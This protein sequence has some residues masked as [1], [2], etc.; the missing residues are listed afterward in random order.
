MATKKKSR[1]ASSAGKVASA[2]SP[3]QPAKAPTNGDRVTLAE[4]MATLEQ[5]GNEQT[6]NT[7]ARHGAQGPM[8]GVKLGD[9]AKLVTR[10]GV[11]HELAMELWNTGNADARTLAVK[12]ADPARM[13]EAD[14]DRWSRE[15]N[16]RL[17]VDYV[18]QLAS[19]G[20]HAAKKA[21]QWLPKKDEQQGL[22]GWTLVGQL[23]M[24][25]AA[26][27]DRWFRDRLAEIEKRIGA[28][29]NLQRAAMNQALIA[30]GGRSAALRD[31]AFAA[32]K[33]IGKVVV[34]HGD[35]SC[36]TPDAVPCLEKMWAHAQAK[37]FE[38]PAAQERTREA[39]RCRC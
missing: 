30:I 37:G 32:S 8:F 4:A 33:R 19:E 22:A 20:P 7:W 36:K 24:R 11:D 23:A 10:I 35:T 15:A 29:P 39:P 25:D 3:K 5:Y 26:T 14:L 28:A 9:L 34:D 1:S 21:A 18:A 27:P 6:R 16:W 2:P 12:V 38:S 31:A 13:S 17:H